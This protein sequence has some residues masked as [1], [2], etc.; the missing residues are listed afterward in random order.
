MIKSRPQFDFPRT[1]LLVV[2]LMVTSMVSAQ[3][4]KSNS[5]VPRQK[6]PKSQPNK[7]VL[8]KLT[9]DQE[10]VALQ[11]ARKHHSRYVP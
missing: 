3:E 11:F 1:L 5:G 4:T 7:V 8:V 9:V 2:V 10:D 6:V